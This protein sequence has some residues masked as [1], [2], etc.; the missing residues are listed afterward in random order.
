MRGAA[1]AAWCAV[2]L[3]W[4][5]THLATGTPWPEL[6]QWALAVGAGVL[7]PGF[8]LVRAVR[9]AAAPLLEDLA[10]AAVAGCVVAM[11]GWAL[12]VVLPWAPPPW[13]TGPVVAAALTA[14]PAARKRILA[15]PAPGW[16]LAA[17]LGVAGSLLVAVAWM[18]TDYLRYNPLDPGAAGHGYYFDTTFQVAVVGELRHSLWPGYPLVSGDPYSYHWFLH[19]ITAHLTTGTGVDPFD[20]M[21]RLVPT[22]VLPAVVLLSAVVARR[23]AGTPRAGAVC[24]ALLT[25]TGATVAT[26]WSTDGEAPLMIQGYWASSLTSEFGWLPTVA[27]A[28]L[29]LAVLRRSADDRAMPV[30][31]LVP[32]VLLAAGAKSADL[33]VLLGGTV[34]A[35]CALLVRRK[36]KV[37]WRAVA[38]NV[39]LGG[40]LLIAR[41]TLYGGGDYGLQIGLAGSI[42]ALAGQL[43]PDAVQRSGSDL[44]LTLPHVPAVPFLAAAVLFLVPLAPRLAGFLPLLRRRPL[45]P[46]MWLFLG[47][48]IAGLGAMLVFRQP[49]NSNYYFL[50]AAYPV[51]LIGSA[52][53][54]SEL[55]WGRAAWVGLAFGVACTLVIAWFVG[56]NPPST[57]SGRL[58]P[59]AVLAL[60]VI[61]LGAL[62]FS[63]KRGTVLVVFALLGTGL[64]ST[65]LYLTQAST[66]PSYNRTV[67]QVGGTDL[68]VTR[69]EL[70]AGRWLN[71]HAGPDDVL[72][73]N[74]VCTQRAGE[75]CTAKLYDM[76]A[77]AQRRVD[78]EGWAYA[79]RNLDSA[80]QSTEW[81]ADQPFWDQPRLNEELT[82][83]T[84][85]SPALLDAL[86][87]RGVHWLVA[88]TRAPVNQKALD[89]LAPRAL[90]LPTM[91]IWRI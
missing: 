5:A 18:T 6:G 89:A 56:A 2:L 23:V 88:D 84:S 83:F 43:F 22:S 24:A 81:Y 75:T 19:A 53:G 54:I 59:L 27:V 34:L 48:L 82:A 30:W 64:L 72:A 1:P 8:A 3:A 65:G 9:A 77:F 29:V 17:N 4:A 21:L 14:I 41:F 63:R 90:T 68:P 39:L 71:E 52:W 58:A 38:I 70:A 42:R 15:K 7:L 28:G 10:W 35:L 73:V 60:A 51:G 61:V 44:C 32:F 67:S 57:I 55:R 36:W 85:P 74:R 76:S 79:P 31:L 62:G 12:D 49:G 46:A 11:V 45:D 78:V 33:A 16:G 91:I 66:K 37:V 86:R 40:V 25:V 69:D 47:T 80:W 13:L 87:A 50:V 20:S 26:I